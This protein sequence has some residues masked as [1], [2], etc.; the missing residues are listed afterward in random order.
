MSN[1]NCFLGLLMLISFTCQSQVMKFMG[2]YDISQVDSIDG[3]KWRMTGEFVDLTGSFTGLD[4]DTNAKIVQRGIDSIGR[5]VYD[6][7]VIVGIISQT[8]LNLVCDVESDYT[9]GIQ[10]VIG[11]PSTGSFPIALPFTDTSKLTYRASFYQNQIDPDYDAAL[12]NLNLYAQNASYLIEELDPYYRADTSN[13]AYLNQQNTFTDRMRIGTRSDTNHYGLMVGYGENTER[14]SIS[15]ISG[16]ENS[17]LNFITASGN[18]TIVKMQSGIMKINNTDNSFDSNLIIS[19]NGYIGINSESAD[20]RLTVVGDIKCDTAISNEINIGEWIKTDGD[21]LKVNGM[22]RFG[23]PTGWPSLFPVE[24]TGVDPGLAIISTG[25][26]SGRNESYVGGY[27][28]DAAGQYRKLGASSFRWSDDNTTNGYGVSETHATYFSSPGVTADNYIWAGFGKKGMAIF[29]SST[30]PSE[31]PGEDILNVNGSVI[32]RDQL[33]VRTLPNSLS[34]TVL[35]DSAWTLK[36]RHISTFGF[37]SA[38]T[39]PVTGTGTSGYLPKFTGASTVG[40]SPIYTDGTN[41]GMGV[42]TLLAK[43]NLISATVIT[44]PDIL[45]SNNLDGTYRNGIGN[46]FVG[47]V[48]ASNKMNLLVC[49]GTATGQISALTLQGNGNVGAGVIFPPSRFS[50]ISSGLENTLD[51]SFT[52]DFSGDYRNGISNVFGAGTAA[53]NKM[54]FRVCDGTATGHNTVLTLLGSGSV[55][56]GTTSPTSGYLLDVNGAIY[57]RSKIV[58]ADSIRTLGQI[59]VGTSVKSV[60]VSPDSA[61]RL[62]GTSTVYDD[63][64][65]PFQTGSLGGGSYPAFV[66]DSGYYDFS[67]IDTTGPSKCVMYITVQLPHRWKS[68]STIYPHVHVKYETGIT[69]K[70]LLKYKWVDNGG[71]VTPKAWSWYLMDQA[72]ATTDKTIQRISG[73]SGISGTGKGISSMLICQVYLAPTSSL[74]VKAYQFDVHIEINKMGSN[75]ETSEN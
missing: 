27:M 38:L 71:V 34:D 5:V 35:I 6:R 12:D 9:T 42:T 37:Q 75:T 16:T 29:P 59:K 67:A 23:P 70:F 72:A 60:I 13:I 46:A 52:N 7:Y 33:K 50:V 66:P 64:M 30:N 63:L 73:T 1:K 43:L 56:I 4:A 20:E 74:N 58:A 65:F 2:R 54:F 19:Q 40:D 55:G 47:G 45:M 17:Y 53:S 22:A 61:I 24:L 62:H 8:A 32:I 44:T 41:V 57:G 69:P 10:N 21:T 39:N 11:W 28:R 36:K 3:V 48:A 26:C 51:Q 14:A 18:G 15:I 68:G 49:D 25:S 31:A